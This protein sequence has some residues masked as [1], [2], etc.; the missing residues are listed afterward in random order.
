MSASKCIWIGPSHEGAIDFIKA[1]GFDVTVTEKFEDSYEE[2]EF[3]VLFHHDSKCIPILENMPADLRDR[4]FVCAWSCS[5]DEDQLLEAGANFVLCGDFDSRVQAQLSFLIQNY[6]E[7]IKWKTSEAKQAKVKDDLMMTIESLEIASKRFETLFNGLP[8]GC[9]TFDS[10]GLIHEWNSLAT[11]LFGIE[12]YSAFFNTVSDVLDPDGVGTWDR[13]VVNQIFTT[14]RGAE[15]DW[16]FTRDDGRVV[17]LACKVLCLT[18]RKGDVIAAVAGNL[19][20]TERVQAQKKVEEQVRE[21]KS[22]LK[23]MERQRL[24]LQD[25]NRQLRRLAVTDGLTGLMNR[26]R[27]NELLDESLDRAMRQNQ[28]FSIILFDIDHFKKLNDEFGHNAGDEILV[29]FANVLKDAARRYERPARY[30]GEEF[31]IVLD[32]CDA[33]GARL[34][35]ERFRTAVN[36]E[37]WPYRDITVSVGC[38]TFSGVES[39]RGMIEFADEALYFAKSQGRNRVAHHRDIPRATQQDSIKIA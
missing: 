27:F 39:A 35:A 20:I 2:G 37:D 11:E 15:F 13:E 34:A 30:G 32:N 18:N 38:S 12:A 1:K 6:N 36:G 5:G 21:I 31:A 29:K 22:Y 3:F 4:C 24:K 19:D 9:F 16:T 26:R 17:H 23:V 25:A 14:D 10:M 8:V 33:H 7:K 28:I